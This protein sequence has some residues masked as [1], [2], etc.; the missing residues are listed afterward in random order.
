MSRGRQ[1]TQNPLLADMPPAVDDL[2]WWLDTY[3]LK[4]WEVRELSMD[5]YAW[6]PRVHVAR[7]SASQK[8]ADRGAAR[9][10]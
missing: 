3:G 8:L 9:R 2:E 6:F 5:E 7:H 1:G 10:K 4:P